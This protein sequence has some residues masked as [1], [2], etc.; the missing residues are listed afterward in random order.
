MLPAIA[1]FGVILAFTSTA[2][3]AEPQN[4]LLNGDAE[5]GKNGQP[6]IWFQA[7][8]PADG[9]VM[10]RD[11]EQAHA[12]KASLFIENRHDYGAQAVANNWGQSLQQLPVG[13]TLV[14]SAAIKTLDADAANVCLQCWDAGGKTMLAFTSTPVVRGDQ[15]WVALRA[16]PLR[17]PADTQSVVVRAALSGKG[18]VW[19]DDISVTASDSAQSAASTKV[20]RLNDALA[21]SKLSAVRTLPIEADQMVLKY[22]QDGTTAA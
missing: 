20:E 14:L 9:L 12:G 2:R 13:K 21:K 5:A 6:S 16:D 1:L 7:S 8:V 11:L 4:L 22:L 15:D 10:G 3:G 17:V 18:K 19:F